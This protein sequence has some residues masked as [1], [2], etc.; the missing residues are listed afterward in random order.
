MITLL[1]A[2]VLIYFL[3]DI[4]LVGLACLGIKIADMFK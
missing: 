2:V 1:V 3:G 4:L